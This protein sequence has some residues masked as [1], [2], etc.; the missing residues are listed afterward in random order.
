MYT[1][2]KHL[3][4]KVQAFHLVKIDVELETTHMNQA[5]YAGA[6]VEGPFKLEHYSTK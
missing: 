3:N 1:L 2:P 5:V 6:K 4:E